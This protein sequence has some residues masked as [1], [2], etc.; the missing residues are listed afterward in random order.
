MGRMVPGDACAVQEKVRAPA[1]SAC[2]SSVIMTAMLSLPRPR[3]TR[4][5]LFSQVFFDPR[6]PAIG[7]HEGREAWLMA[8]GWKPAAYFCDGTDV[9][10]GDAQRAV[11]TLAARGILDQHQRL[12]PRLA[13]SR[14]CTALR[15]TIFVQIGQTEPVT[16]LRD[17]AAHWMHGRPDIGY[18]MEVAFATAL[19]YGPDDI[20]HFIWRAYG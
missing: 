9:E 12:I 18:R 13:P 8:L 15:E 1:L 10:P 2:G 3:F 17:V 16:R 7:P 6:W 19:G 14:I 5:D 4:D 20:R 11:L